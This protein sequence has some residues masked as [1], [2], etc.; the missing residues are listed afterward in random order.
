M[1]DHLQHQITGLDA[2]IAE[3]DEAMRPLR[4]LI[5]ELNAEMEKTSWILNGYQSGRAYDQAKARRSALSREIGKAQNKLSDIKEERDR[6]VMQRNL[7]QQELDLQRQA[8]ITD[9]E[10]DAL[11]DEA[12]AT[13]R[14]AR[15]R[16]AAA[17]DTLTRA[18]AQMTEIEA[19]EQASTD[20]DAALKELR[21]KAFLAG[22]GKSQVALGSAI[23]DAELSATAARER[24]AGASAAR[25]QVQAAIDA[26]TRRVDELAGELQ[27]AEQNA[28]A[29]R[30]QVAEVRAV[31]TFNA[32]IDQLQALV[33]GVADANPAKGRQL[34]LALAD[35]GLQVYDLRGR[36]VTPEWLRHAATPLRRQLGAVH[37]PQAHASHSDAQESGDD[38]SAREQLS[39]THAG[40]ALLNGIWPADFARG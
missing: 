38:S 40:Q 18:T 33:Q 13:E 28:Q 16:H 22:K 1:T 5:D 37:M 6:L 35:G 24:A 15:K 7:A 36:L 29:T 23:D 34:A 17:A 26:A 21:G 3:H 20:S 31:R 11:I 39:A 4:D 30:T 19:A 8:S 10:M 14:D 27:A 12:D 2:R 25:P 9:D 32:A